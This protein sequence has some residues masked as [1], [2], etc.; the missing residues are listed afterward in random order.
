MKFVLKFLPVLLALGLAAPALHAQREKLPPED[1]E[2]VEK[3]WPG[4]KKT[5]TG[6]RYVVMREGTGAIPKAGSKVAVIYV[7][8]LLNGKVFN[9]MEDK[10]NPFVFRIRRGEVIEG[11][12]QILQLMKVGEKRMVIIPAEMAYGTRGR[13][14]DIPR[15]ATLVFEIDLLEIKPE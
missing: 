13:P 3:T 5:V 4:A 14:P 15:S 1:L 12:D 7:G 10:A 6:L 8:R 11:W 2:Y 9:Q